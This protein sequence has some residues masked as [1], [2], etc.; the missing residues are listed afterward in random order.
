MV[1]V[2]QSA[3]RPRVLILGA[4]GR[5][6]VSCTLCRAEGHPTPDKGGARAPDTAVWECQGAP[7]AGAAG[8]A[9][10]TRRCQQQPPPTLPRLQFP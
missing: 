1:G 2:A 10:P 9:P 8:A 7:A 3:K 6:C 5:E 4:A